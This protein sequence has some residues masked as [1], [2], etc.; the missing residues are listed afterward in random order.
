MLISYYE[1]GKAAPKQASRTMGALMMV[2]ALLSL[3]ILFAWTYLSMF[4]A[5]PLAWATWM[6]VNRGYGF[7]GIFDYPFLMLWLMPLVGICG[8]WLC[9]KSGREIVAFSFVGIPLVMLLLIV[10]WFYL[11]P[12]DWH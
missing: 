4:V 2:N 1:D 11:T 6:P 10:G 3:G 7:N 9:L 12:P 5:E 8:A